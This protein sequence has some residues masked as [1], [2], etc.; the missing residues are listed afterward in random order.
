MRIPRKD[1]CPFFVARREDGCRNSRGGPVDREHGGGCSIESC[2][3][4]LRLFDD[5]GWCEE[6]VDFLELG[7]V[8]CKEWVQ[9]GIDV[10]L[11][12]IVVQI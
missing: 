10:S 6:V 4:L 7:H 11:S 5:P 3:K 2:G 12:L 8:E 1:E 9:A